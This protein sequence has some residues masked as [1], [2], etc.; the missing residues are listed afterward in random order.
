MQ[1]I[2]AILGLSNQLSGQNQASQG[3]FVKGNK[4]LQE[5]D[6]VMQ[7]ANGRDQMASLLLESQ[8]LTPMKEIMKLNILQ[9]AGGDTIFNR[10]K[11]IVV[12]IDPAALRKAV[13]EFKVTDGLTPA[14]KI[15]NTDTLSVAFQVLGS[16][17]NIAAEYNVGQLFSYLMKSQGSDI[18]S[19][20]K[21]PAQ[22]AYEQALNSWQQ[23]AAIALEKGLDPE[24][25]PPQP[26]PQQFGYNPEDN[27]PAPDERLTAGEPVS[28]QAPLTP[29]NQTNGGTNS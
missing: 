6:S 15:L 18:G 1:Q 19:F 13:L 2:Q 22:I 11:N 20:E 26:L 7:N 9:F 14:S 5:F 3:Q 24:K 17:P 21:S 8:L 28:N 23:L 27:K 10:D 4:T 29:G 12:E 25:L 16:A